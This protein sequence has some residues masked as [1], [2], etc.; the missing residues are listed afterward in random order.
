LRGSRSRCRLR[1]GLASAR[2]WA[3]F[4]LL[5]LNDG[6]VGDKR[7]LQ[8]DWV[9]FS[10]AATLDTDYGAGFWTNRSE[11][12]HAKGRVRAGKPRD[13]F[14]ASGN[15]GQRIVILPSQRMVV[16]R[17]G[18]SVDPDGDI[19]GLTRLVREVIAATQS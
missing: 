12:E 18:D 16:V 2:D 4:G 3:R 8:E 9:S 11:H 17:L 7:I 13:A 19:R 10:P 1:C 5:Y 14:F 6:V 15:L